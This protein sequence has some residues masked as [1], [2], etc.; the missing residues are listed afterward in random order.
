MY[1]NIHTFMNAN[2]SPG[3]DNLKAKWLTQMAELW[4]AIKGSLALV[5]KPCIR[6]N[7]QACANGQKHP[8]WILAVV[9]GG[10]RSSLYVPEALVGQIKQAIKNGR[11]IEDKLQQAA[12]Q[13]V[14]NHRRQVKNTK[15]PSTNS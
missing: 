2:R 4:P 10:K 9:T 7:C 13:M 14:K 15:N 3:K 6:K 11:T 1:Y 12:I 5:H 8:A